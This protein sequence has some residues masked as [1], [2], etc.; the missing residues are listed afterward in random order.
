MVGGRDTLGGADL[1]GFGRLGGPGRFDWLDLPYVDKLLHAGAF[2]ILALLLALAS[3]RPLLALV[4]ASAYGVSDELHQ[5]AVPG[6]SA[7]G[8][9][10]LADTVGAGLVAAVV[11]LWRRPRGQRVE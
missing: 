2:G 7:S 3:G 11:F 5:L 9:D 1:P 4:L 8:L 10:W 6:R